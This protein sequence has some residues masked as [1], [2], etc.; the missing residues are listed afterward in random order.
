MAYATK[1]DIQ[2]R[3]SITDMLP[4]LDDEST[5]DFSSVSVQEVFNSLLDLESARVDGLISSIYSVPL[6]PTPPLLRDACTIFVCYSMYR[7]RL[8]P[9]EKNP[10]KQDYDDYYLKLKEI[11]EGKS[12]LDQNFPRA[13]TQGAVI[14]TP[15]AVNSTMM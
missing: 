8:T 3:I 13:F 15:I 14:Q 11:G 5:G 9:D 12:N 6:V 10:F 4:M 7:R 2:A 1:S